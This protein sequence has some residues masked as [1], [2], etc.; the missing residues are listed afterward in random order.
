V[1]DYVSWVITHRDGGVL[2]RTIQLDR[3]ECSNCNHWPVVHARV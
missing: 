2:G 3:K 1:N